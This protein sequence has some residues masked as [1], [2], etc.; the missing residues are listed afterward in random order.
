MENIYR[1]KALPNGRV[2]YYR[3]VEDDHGLAVGDLRPVGRPLRLRE[4]PNPRGLDSLESVDVVEGRIPP[5]AEAFMY[6]GD[7]ATETPLVQC[8]AWRLKRCS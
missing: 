8:Y 5:G 2:R 1:L 3:T 6:L 4:L 7:P